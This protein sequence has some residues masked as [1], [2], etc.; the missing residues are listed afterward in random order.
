MLSLLAL[1]L[2]ASGRFTSG[3]GLRR[4]DGAVQFSKFEERVV[5]ELG[6]GRVNI[7]AGTVLAEDGIGVLDVSRR[8]CLDGI[9]KR[10]ETGDD[11]CP[12]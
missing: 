5:A 6:Q 3:I 1:L 7:E 4:A 10:C 2:V 8:E 9:L 12:H 11:L